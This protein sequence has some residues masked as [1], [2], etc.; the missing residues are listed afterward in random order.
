MVTSK[1]ITYSEKRTKSILT[2]R[3]GVVLLQ[4][5]PVYTH[6]KN[7]VRIERPFRL[8]SFP[9]FLDSKTA[10]AP[11]TASVHFL[12]K[13]TRPL[14]KRNTFTLFLW[15][16]IQLTLARSVPPHCWQFQMKWTSL[17][18]THIL[19][20]KSSPSLSTYFLTTKLNPLKEYLIVVSHG[21]V[22]WAP[23]GLLY[24]HWK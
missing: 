7:H 13:F 11:P 4:N 19:L 24:I 2:S 1:N 17:L 23:F 15:T 22:L 20:A 18:S 6:W 16:E 14:S 5:R 12:Q 8:F 10:P 9:K 21:V 3:P